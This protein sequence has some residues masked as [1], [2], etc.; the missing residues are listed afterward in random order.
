[1]N[2]PRLTIVTTNYNYGR[3]LAAAIES[4]ITQDY[5]NL[6]YFVFDAGSTDDSPSI[7]ARYADH[8]AGWHSQR[9]AGPAAALNLGLRR[10]TGEWFY[11]LNSDDFL[12]PGALRRFGEVVRAA[13]PRLWLSGGRHEV[14]G[15]G[16]FLRRRLPWREETHLFALA[17]MWHAAEGTFLHLPALRRSGFAFDESYHNIFDTVLYTL[18][19]RHEPPLYVDA[20]FGAMRLHGA[21]KSLPG[22]RAAVAAEAARHAQVCGRPGPLLRVAERLGRTRFARET[23]RLLAGAYF[24]GLLGRRPPREAAIPDDRGGFTVLPLRGALRRPAATS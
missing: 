21:N 12:L 11:Y 22:N 23:E 1:M 8:L 13:G 19:D 2:W 9:D 5:P 4:V 18:L 17:R 14:D 20:F 15:E 24:A 7:V 3:F 16:R 6:E 10:A